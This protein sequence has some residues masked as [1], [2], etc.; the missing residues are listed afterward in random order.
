MADDKKKNDAITKKL[1]NALAPALDFDP[2]AAVEDLLAA[3][4]K[5]EPIVTLQAGEPFIGWLIGPGKV[6]L[7]NNK[8][9]DA[10]KGDDGKPVKSKIPAWRFRPFIKGLDGKQD[11]AKSGK[12]VVR[13]PT[14][15][16]LDSWCQEA[17]P[18]QMVRITKRL[19]KATSGAGRP[20]TVFDIVELPHVWTDIPE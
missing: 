5:M 13:V 10:P 16:Q 6:V 19:E 2:T 3:G 15:T 18:G 1:V 17:A 12:F 14:A 7:A 9:P 4:A 11:S 20:V 8:N